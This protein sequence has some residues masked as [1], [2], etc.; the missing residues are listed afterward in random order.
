MY[1]GLHKI[2]F[3]LEPNFF[4]SSLKREKNIVEVIFFDSENARNIMVHTTSFFTSNLP[5]HFRNCIKN[6]RKKRLWAGGG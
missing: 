6:L 2:L 3:C 4:I 1:M 5:T